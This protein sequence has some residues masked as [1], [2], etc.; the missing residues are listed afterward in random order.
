LVRRDDEAPSMNTPEDETDFSKAMERSMQIRQIYQELEKRKHGTAWTTQ[1]DMIG[2]TYDVGELGRML[3]AAEGRWVYP[4]DLKQDLGDK[5]AECMWWL[6]VLSGRLGV[7]MNA[8]FAGKMAGLE[9]SLS[10][11]LAGTDSD[12]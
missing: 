8:A 4:G 6:F 12:A 10:S 3:M 2:F 7:D 11:S 1:E 9:A 5:L